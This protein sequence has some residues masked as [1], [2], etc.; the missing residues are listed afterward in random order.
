MADTPAF[1][2]RGA[3]YSDFAQRQQAYQAK[4]D[5]HRNPP[6]ETDDSWMKYVPDVAGNA[7]QQAYQEARVQQQ[8]DLPYESRSLSLPFRST[9]QPS[10][11]ERLGQAAS[12]IANIATGAAAGITGTGRVGQGVNQLQTA[13]MHNLGPEY[14]SQAQYLPEKFPKQNVEIAIARALGTNP[15]L[16]KKPALL[17]AAA[18]QDMKAHDI[19]RLATYSDFAD[20]YNAMLT[21]PDGFVNASKTMTDRINNEASRVPAQFAGHVI[22]TAAHALSVALKPAMELSQAGDKTGKQ[23]KQ[24]DQGL[25]QLGVIGVSGFTNFKSHIGEAF[26]TVFDV[27]HT[28]R[29]LHDIRATQGDAA[30]YQ[31]LSTVV[32]TTVATTFAMDGLGK[33]VLRSGGRALTD[34]LIA[35]GLDVEGLN[36]AELRA[37]AEKAG[38]SPEAHKAWLSAAA[39]WLGKLPPSVQPKVVKILAELGY[40]G[41]APG[42][43]AVDT[44][45]GITAYSREGG[46]GLTTAEE[47]A[48]SGAP[49]AESDVGAQPTDIFNRLGNFVGRA[50]G[51]AGKV[52]SNT[53]GLPFKYPKLPMNFQLASQLLFNTNGLGMGDHWK[54]SWDRTAD[55]K[56]YVDPHTKRAVSL[57][58]EVADVFGG[59][60]NDWWYSAVSGPLDLFTFFALDPTM[61]VLKPMSAAKRLP[62]LRSRTDVYNMM[63]TDLRAQEMAD[64]VVRINVRAKVFRDA[65]IA[66]E[67]KILE[68]SMKERRKKLRLAG[69]SPE[70]IAQATSSSKWRPTDA[71]LEA[72]VRNAHP[73]ADS[74][75]DLL[76]LF[77]QLSRPVE[78]EE[79]ALDFIAKLTTAESRNDVADILGDMAAANAMLDPYRLPSYGQFTR[80]K[81]YLYEKNRQAIAEGDLSAMGKMQKT[82]ARGAVSI[83]PTYFQDLR[84]FSNKL[85]RV[86]S[87]SSL[88]LIRRTFLAAGRSP[89]EVDL[90]INRLAR[91]TNDF[92]W[93]TIYKNFVQDQFHIE[94]KAFVDDLVETKGFSPY[95][96]ATLRNALERPFRSVIE[97]LSETAGGG[98]SAAAYTGTK[99]NYVASMTDPLSSDMR[100]TAGLLGAH[101]H[102]FAL[103]D[104]VAWDKFKADIVKGLRDESPDGLKAQMY[105]ASKDIVA[106][107]F[108]D[109]I[110][111]LTSR[112]N[113]LVRQIAANRKA[114]RE[115]AAVIKQSR[116]SNTELQAARKAH[117]ANLVQNG[118]NLR[119]ADVTRSKL[120]QALKD[121]QSLTE[122]ANANP[123]N[124][125]LI[126][127]MLAKNAEIERLRIEL[128][129]R[130][131]EVDA[132]KPQL[133]QSKKTL[134]AANKAQ[135]TVE[136]PH[137][138]EQKQLNQKTNQ[139]KAQIDAY[140]QQIKSQALERDA[141]IVSR[142]GNFKDFKVLD[143]A[144][145]DAKNAL[146][147]FHDSVRHW[148]IDKYFRQAVLAT[149]SFSMRVA[150]AEAI[151]NTFRV[152]AREYSKGWLAN[153][154]AKGIAEA[155]GVGAKQ[156]TE[157]E[158]NIVMSM[159]HDVLTQLR[160][161]KATGAVKGSINSFLEGLSSGLGM[162]DFVELLSRDIIERGGT[163][164]GINASHGSMDA[165]KFM[166]NLSSGYGT[167]NW[168]FR[169][170]LDNDSLSG[171]TKSLNDTAHFAPARK[172]AEI[173]DKHLDP[174]EMS[175][176][177]VYKR[178]EV[179]RE[180]NRD[181]IRR[182]VARDPKKY[183]AMLRSGAF[184]NDA[185][186]QR[187]AQ[188]VMQELGV[189]SLESQQARNLLL[190]KQSKI[191]PV[192]EWAD[193]L[194][195]HVLWLS[196]GRGKTNDL[197]DSANISDKVFHRHVLK[198][199]A[200]GKAPYTPEL[201][202][203]LYIKPDLEQARVMT[204]QNM[205]RAKGAEKS[206]YH[207]H[208][209]G[210]GGTSL[211]DLSTLSDVEIAH[212]GLPSRRLESDEAL[213][214]TFE[215]MKGH[216][217]HNAIIEAN[218]PMKTGFK[219]KFAGKNKNTVSRMYEDINGE[220]TSR[221]PANIPTQVPLPSSRSSALEAISSKT[222]DKGAEWVH[223]TIS[224]PVINTIAREPLYAVEFAQ[225]MNALKPLVKDGTLPL[226]VAMNT[227]RVR[228]I[229]HAIKFVHNP[230][231]RFVF[232]QWARA[233]APFWFA[234]NQA[235]RR[236]GRLAITNP[237]GFERYL[238]AML[239]MQNYGAASAT[240]NDNQSAI[241]M[242][243][244]MMGGRLMTDFM[245]TIGFAP[246]GGVPLGL[247]GSTSSLASVFPWTDPSGENPGNAISLAESLRPDFG[248]MVSLPIRALAMANPYNHGI[249][250]LNDK[251]LGALGSQSSLFQQMVPNSLVRSVISMGSSWMLGGR[252]QTTAA[253][254]ALQTGLMAQY[255]QSKHKELAKGAAEQAQFDWSSEHDKFYTAQHPEEYK[256]YVDAMTTAYVNEGIWYG[257]KEVQKPISY[258]Y[259]DPHERTYA[260]NRAHKA[261]LAIYAAR[262]VLSF[263]S[264]LSLTTTEVNPE[265][266]SLIR[267]AQGTGG[268]FTKA[269]A[270]YNKHPDAIYYVA[271]G[272]AT[273]T[274]VPLP[275]TLD[276][277]K[278][279]N[280]NADLFRKGGNASGLIA[281]VPYTNKGDKFDS[282]EYHNQLAAGLRRSLTP[283]EFL[284]KMAAAVG[285][286]YVYNYLPKLN[287][288]F[289]GGNTESL[290][291][292]KALYSRA[293]PLWAK[294]LGDSK[295]SRI[296]A[297][298]Q[299]RQLLNTP[300]INSRE[301]FK[302]TAPRIREMVSKYD[303][304]TQRYKNADSGWHTYLED[305]WQ[306]W[307][308][309]YSSKHKEITI[310]ANA[311]FKGLKLSDNTG[312]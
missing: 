123:Q 202:R 156:I 111:A 164:W 12:G 25:S 109:Q 163:L 14:Y 260:I 270:L 155:S 124:T 180:E 7:A 73:E 304:F 218:T 137:R 158:R 10:I 69:A 274:G 306:N 248:P 175:G 301:G 229:E 263:F 245:K 24:S 242:P 225:Q 160:I 247:R 40:E 289:E 221:F 128:E 95:E 312:N 115:A 2:G 208:L 272:T 78:G 46:L 5:A 265:M 201:T 243:G 144:G 49:I 107:P 57:G 308:T 271:H 261:A 293:N 102:Y 48:L 171:L 251:A 241:L 135:K 134:A 288:K 200:E 77:P 72:L 58:R 17:F 1:R 287:D 106:K 165:V 309:E 205:K 74:Y 116:E 182:M 101:E 296:N 138:L 157:E 300:G 54:D 88:D 166:H 146:Y 9:Y 286:N 230:Q 122:Q 307:L 282:N 4:V 114:W 66:E 75:A 268:D 8:G 16:V 139:L 76:R 133:D 216:D 284:D 267:D 29:A 213:T 231:D 89:G 22:D 269:E 63:A 43:A 280:E 90:L 259:S 233:F 215:G 278:F 92:E 60:P 82:L 19:Q 184:I 96:A 81:D 132:F 220:T 193:A 80:M 227:A 6:K 140:K 223:D 250:Q 55:G 255:L 311:I 217:V 119:E 195:E 236:A 281:F 179:A 52:L 244:S 56:T 143:K 222:I 103:P 131:N 235:M 226:E 219:N 224:T 152:G 23:F 86:G 108:D 3:A 153:R 36:I 84:Q 50:S 279:Q 189:T 291:R 117:E 11:A 71:Q 83:K 212:L 105:N 253:I 151:A 145:M 238:R 62:P 192:D 199:L 93:R 130:Y 33:L 277:S 273:Q 97:Q 127:D 120:K 203:D 148:F 161:P 113:E 61:A 67:R 45:G 30:Y 150:A 258:Y 239:V 41:A 295:K 126:H 169:N 28:V 197:F 266:R 39:K 104:Y 110:A 198:M 256:A 42:A 21:T 302:T 34:A 252:N 173:L 129:A 276:M 254:D 228:A 26:N 232:E 125:Q 246:A 264:P 283:P 15:S 38:V 206:S 51:P 98:A 188:E 64:A 294:T 159:V 142:L 237:M 94:A 100:P 196:H 35:N 68:S 70:Q 174:A 37:L 13:D 292:A 299:V 214:P 59:K 118:T 147:N 18:T 44:E 112:N 149:G 210:P 240:N 185:T 121:R 191:N 310:G 141:A 91:T 211:T 234:K 167:G 257:D 204:R 285:N 154:V 47:D 187:L 178:L 27:Q 162:D 297:L 20:A 298:D 209:Y 87:P 262:T 207:S 31:A 249:Q 65:K 177:D 85:A 305:Q 32:G 290:R 99:H 181:A 53:V 186:H 170:T 172:T 136:T 303:E 183:E 275:A 176:T 168:E 190:I 79:P 194:F